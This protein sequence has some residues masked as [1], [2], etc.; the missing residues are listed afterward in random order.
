MRCRRGT[1]FPKPRWMSVHWVYWGIFRDFSTDRERNVS[2]YG[3]NGVAGRLFV[4]SRLLPVA[5]RRPF[6]ERIN[7]QQIRVCSNGGRQKKGCANVKSADA[8]PITSNLR[9][10]YGVQDHLQQQ[11]YRVPRSPHPRES[12][13]CCEGRP[14]RCQRLI[15]RRCGIVAAT[16]IAGDLR[17][18]SARCANYRILALPPVRARP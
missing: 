7:T 13:V 2:A 11:T 8:G 10:R 16:P 9:C 18:S 15:R 12:R 17:S 3:R 4:I 1:A 14:G 5:W 6:P